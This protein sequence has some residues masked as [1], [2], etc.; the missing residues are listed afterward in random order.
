MN[1][2]VFEILPSLE[3][4]V[5]IHIHDIMYPFEYPKEWIYQGRAWNEVYL[6]HALLQF[7]ETFEIV[8]FNSYLG[9]FHRDLFESM[10][11]FLRNPGTSLWLRKR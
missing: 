10:P 3:S 7:N 8:F 1:H 5:Y 4:G 11:L 2:I 6:V 9:Q